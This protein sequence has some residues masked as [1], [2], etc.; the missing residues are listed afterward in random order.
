MAVLTARLLRLRQELAAG[1]TDGA[2]AD[3]LDRIC[4]AVTVTA[5]EEFTQRLQVAA[6]TDP[7]TG[8]GNRRALDHAW[9]TALLQGRRLGAPVCVVAIDLDGLKRINDLQGHA[10]GDEAIVR[11]CAALRAALRTTDAVFRIGGD[12]FV[13]LLP[14]TSAAGATELI[15]RVGQFDAPRFSWGA[16]DTVQD[17][18]TLET[19]LACADRRLYARRRRTRPAQALGSVL[20]PAPRE[21]AW[22]RLTPRRIRELA[23]SG[24]LS[25]A[26][27][28]IVVTIAGGNHAL[29]ASGGGTGIVDCG[30]SNAVY[31]GGTVLM[32]AGALVLGAGVV[33]RALQRGL[34]DTERPGGGR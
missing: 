33:A 10:A 26:I 28:A 3:R 14:G 22:A 25:L 31:Y 17:G 27:G 29:C 16:A 2:S 12:E 18:T 21:S 11:L 19:T 30:L 8:A 23:V 7:L 6:M 15:D 24:A 32:V 9:H 34:A 4:A 13:V 20:V 5:T 1:E